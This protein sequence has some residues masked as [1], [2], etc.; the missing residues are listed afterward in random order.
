MLLQNLDH[1]SRKYNRRF[2]R[3]TAERTSL[4]IFWGIQVRIGLDAHQR[5]GAEPF[6]PYGYPGCYQCHTW[7]AVST[8]SIFVDAIRKRTLTLTG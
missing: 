7:E 3:S 8:C 1:A 2:V 4:L 5:S 6:H